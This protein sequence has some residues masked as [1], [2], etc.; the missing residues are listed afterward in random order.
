L[1]IGSIASSLRDAV[2]LTKP[3]LS[4]F[5]VFTAAMGLWL[6]PGELG[7]AR[8]AFILVAIGMLVGAANILNCWLERET[9]ALM[10]R[11]RNRPLPAGRVDPWSAFALGVGVAAFALPLL[12]LAANPLT[13]L[14]GLAALAAYVLAY[15]PLKRFTPWALEVGAIPGAIPPLMGW[16]AATGSLE[17]QAWTLFGILFFWQLPHFIGI[18]IW[19]QDD[20][21][22]GGIRVL[23]VVRG[24]RVATRY[25]FAYASA[26]VATSLT[27]AAFGMTGRSYPWIAAGLGAALLLLAASGFRETAGR[28]WARRTFLFSLLYLAALLLALVL[29]AR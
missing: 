26:L 7:A 8:G 19:L 11:T 21:S 23:P 4:T 9:D 15:T 29:D 1:T 13:A 25:L 27:P 3:R 18:A 16:A 2:D 28:S 14:L 22:R 17:P 10:H 24:A 6:A 20:Y 5:V 12:A